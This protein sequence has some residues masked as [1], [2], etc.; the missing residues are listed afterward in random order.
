MSGN[1]TAMVGSRKKR[2]SYEFRTTN[3]GRPP[4][5]N[6]NGPW[7]K[8]KGS[9]TSRQT[10]RTAAKA[11]GEMEN[12]SGVTATYRRP[13]PEKRVTV[14]ATAKK[15]SVKAAAMT[16]ARRTAGRTA[17]RTAGRTPFRTGAR[18]SPST[19]RRKYRM[20]QATAHRRRHLE[21][22]PRIAEREEKERAEHSATMNNF[23]NRL[24]KVHLG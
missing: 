20:N 3:D 19:T 7:E 18:N 9:N 8:V 17:R 22:M 2:V 11:A 23:A 4:A 16:A 14:H 1:N 10:R 13:K 24:G 5:N 21:A 6:G 15:T 12:K